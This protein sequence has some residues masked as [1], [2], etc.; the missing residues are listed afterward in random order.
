[1]EA[2]FQ[3]LAANPINA[4]VAWIGFPV[5]YAVSGVLLTVLGSV[6]VVLS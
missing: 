4:A 5:G 3:F 2:V 1:M 6:A